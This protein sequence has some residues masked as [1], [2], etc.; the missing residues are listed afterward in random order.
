MASLFSSTKNTRRLIENSNRF[1]RS[2][3]PAALDQNEIQWLKDQ[4]V[5]T[6]IDLRE[7]S[8]QALKPCI[9]KGDPC[10]DYFTMPVTGGN[11]IPSNPEDVTASYIKMCDENMEKIIDKIVYSYSNVLYFCNAGKDRT[12]VVSAILLYTL[13]YDD[14][15]IV[16]DYM[17]SADE[18]K[19]FLSDHVK[20]NIN[21]DINVI[22]PHEEYITSF[23]GWY[24]KN[25]T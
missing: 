21:A 11:M 13:G 8:E 23:L 24:K 6:V 14:N 7:R 5:F 1:I 9:L 2:D 25:K 19:E 12:G 4:N 16:R 18:L 22:T 20:A 15:Y 17:R 10:F 3:V